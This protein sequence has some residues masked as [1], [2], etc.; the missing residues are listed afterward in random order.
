MALRT[1][2]A[3][4]VNDENNQLP[5]FTGASSPSARP[6][7][8]PPRQTMKA[9]SA[10]SRPASATVPQDYNLE[11][12]RSRRPSEDMLLPRRR[13]TLKN[14]A[15]T[16]RPAVGKAAAKRPASAVTGDKG[17]ITMEARAR[18]ASAPGL[19]RVATN[20]FAIHS[21]VSRDFESMA[22]D[23]RLARYAGS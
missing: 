4:D 5:G 18:P 13:Q 22:R 19:Q 15:T 20:E 14:P 17:S 11:A 16:H 10:M 12:A 6:H 3:A 21:Q 1:A 9:P 7:S 8:A 23:L 2:A